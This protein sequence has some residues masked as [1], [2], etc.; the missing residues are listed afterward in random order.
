MVQNSSTALHA[1]KH[2]V[3]FLTQPKIAK[4]K[5][6]MAGKGY[7]TPESG[8]IK[9]NECLSPKHRPKVPTAKECAEGLSPRLLKTKQ[10]RRGTIDLK[11]A[12]NLQALN[13]NREQFNK[14]DDLMELYDASHNSQVNKSI[15]DLSMRQDDADASDQFDNM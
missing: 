4:K 10:N 8:K 1:Q 9:N 11:I 15:K 14:A 5:K 6:M 3:S 13:L 2:P 12:N 7:L